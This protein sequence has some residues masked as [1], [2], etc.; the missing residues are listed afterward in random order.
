MAMPFV[1]KAHLA[2]ER[3]F[4]RPRMDKFRC[5]LRKENLFLVPYDIQDDAKK[6]ST[7]FKARQ[8]AVR[9]SPH[10]TL[11]EKNATA[12]TTL[13][14]KLSKLAQKLGLNAE[15]KSTEPFNITGNLLTLLFEK[16]RRITSKL[17]RSVRRRD[18]LRL[19]REVAAGI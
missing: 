1:A 4:P 5:E 10:S 16:V 2:Y 14:S 3:R 11:A 18:V 17:M 9:A 19:A 12:K 7:S 13:E 6:F 8:F 15:P